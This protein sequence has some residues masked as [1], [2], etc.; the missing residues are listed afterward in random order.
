M[1]TIKG[2]KLNEPESD[3]S[4]SVKKK[5]MARARSEWT[6]HVGPRRDPTGLQ[7]STVGAGTSA[8]AKATE[9]SPPWPPELSAPPWPPDP[10]VP[11][12]P[13]FQYRS[14]C[15]ARQGKFIYIAHFIHSGNSK[16]FT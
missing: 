4:R 9:T 5:K 13:Q 14:G 11:P 7:T 16:C 10:P 2:E 3:P 15:K 8:E 12:W 6:Q 1:G